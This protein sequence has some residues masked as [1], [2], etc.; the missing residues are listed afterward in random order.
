MFRWFFAQQC[1]LDASVQSI[2]MF[3]AQNGVGKIVMTLQKYPSNERRLFQQ[4]EKVARNFEARRTLTII[5]HLKRI[6]T[7]KISNLYGAGPIPRAL[8]CSRSCG[9]DGAAL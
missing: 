1:E 4:S 7:E 8:D 6:N 2:S 9:T 3:Q 5:I